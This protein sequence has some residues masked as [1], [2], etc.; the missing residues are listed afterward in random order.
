MATSAPARLLEQIKGTRTGTPPTFSS[1]VTDYISGR[2]MRLFVCRE[3]ECC[4][5][6][7]ENQYVL[8]VPELL[9]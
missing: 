5:L 6:V 1:E 2:Y 3:A 4:G 7:A 8:E 9:G